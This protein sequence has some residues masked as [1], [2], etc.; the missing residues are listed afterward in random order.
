MA[1]LTQEFVDL[2]RCPATG[3]RLVEA[4]ES[5][6]GRLRLRRPEADHWLLRVDGRAAYPVCKGLPLLLEE[7]AV[8]VCE[9]EGEFN[10]N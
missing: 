8:V 2:L 7:E 3:Q 10:L 1:D 4:T 9:T 6:G 5:L